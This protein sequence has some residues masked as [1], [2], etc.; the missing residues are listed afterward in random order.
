MDGNVIGLRIDLLQSGEHNLEGFGVF[1]GGEG[2]VA[3]HAL[4]Y[5]AETLAAFMIATS[6][7]MRPKPIKPNRFLP[8]SSVPT[9]CARFHSPALTLTLACGTLRA[10]REQKRH[11][12]FRG[13]NRVAAGDV[14]DHDALLAGSRRDVDVVDVP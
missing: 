14:D 2:I 13:G 3:D 10:H 1:F 11:R 5:V 9:N 4:R 8:C 12:V 7:P 6:R